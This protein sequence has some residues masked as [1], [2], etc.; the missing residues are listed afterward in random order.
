LL[1]RVL[2]VAASLMLAGPSMVAGQFSP[3]SGLARRKPFEAFSA[4]AERLRDSASAKLHSVVGSLPI[5]AGSRTAAAVAADSAA[6]ADESLD[7]EELQDSIVTL[8]RAQLGIH[9]RWGAESPARGF[10][11]SG[12]V[13]FVLSLLRLDVPR[14]ARSQSLVGRPVERDTSRLR[15]GDLLTFGAGKGV[16]HVGIY[17]GAGHFVHASTTRRQ[18]VESTIGERGSWYTR[19]WLGARRLLAAVDTA[20]KGP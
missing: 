3:S 4:S 11:C 5:I 16:T 10:D 12:L 1:R 14:T 15:P 7:A 17:V 6:A 19:H 13:R 2:V 8:V 20:G 18:V 9:Y